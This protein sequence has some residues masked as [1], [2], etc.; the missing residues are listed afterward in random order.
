MVSRQ[1]GRRETKT[2]GCYQDKKG[3]SS[4]RK[5]ELL[6]TKATEDHIKWAEKH[7]LDLTT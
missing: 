7:L 4:G 5:K 6:V 3:E 2:G 1:R